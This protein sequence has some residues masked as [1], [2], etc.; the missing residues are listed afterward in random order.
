MNWIQVLPQMLKER[1]IVRDKIK[2]ENYFNNFITRD[3]LRKE[4]YS[5]M[6]QRIIEKRGKDD[7]V[8]SEITHD[9]FRI[10]LHILTAS[11]SMGKPVKD[12]H[13][14]FPQL[15]D[16]FLQ[17]KKCSYS[18]A[19]QA[20]S[21]CILFD[22][23]DYYRKIKEKT[24]ASNLVDNFMKFLF[25]DTSLV[26]SCKGFPEY[27]KIAN[28][29]DATDK[30]VVVKD[31]LSSWYSDN[32]D[33]YWYNSHDSKNDTYFGYWC[34]ESAAVVK[35]LNLNPSDFSNNDYF[36]CDLL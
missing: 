16:W 8:V 26:T 14:L 27:N 5:A 30:T 2:D 18:N 22:Y 1:L 9:L 33:S 12:M 13:N 31:Y 32:K 10:S 17:I 19:I 20:V 25:Q 11:Y 7:E 15:C 36:P 21:L 35:I 24:I 4:K 29:A 3:I 28:I 23:D 6:R 34:F